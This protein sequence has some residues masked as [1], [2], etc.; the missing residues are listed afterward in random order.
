[1]L[2]AIKIIQTSIAFI[3]KTFFFDSGNLRDTYKFISIAQD[4]IV[5]KIFILFYIVFFFPLKLT[6]I[7]SIHCRPCIREDTT[8]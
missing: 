6:A 2:E 3:I 7:I 5:I 8:Q 4:S 1:M